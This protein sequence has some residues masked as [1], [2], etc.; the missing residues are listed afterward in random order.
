MLNVEL[1]IFKNLKHYWHTLLP[2]YINQTVLPFS[3]RPIWG[4]QN[5]IHVI[6]HLP[7]QLGLESWLLSK[8]VVKKNA[9]WVLHTTATIL[10]PSV[11]VI[12][13]LCRS[14]NW[15]LGIKLSAGECLP[16]MVWLGKTLAS[17]Q[18]QEVLGRLSVLLEGMIMRTLTFA[19]IFSFEVCFSRVPRDFPKC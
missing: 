6:L 15:V 8:A 7:T 5:V 11:I 12:K 16:G 9:W 17:H 3:L 19:N 10:G 4:M 14:L 13:W 18:I 1:S 2:H